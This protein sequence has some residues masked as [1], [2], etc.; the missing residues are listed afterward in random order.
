[1]PNL[2]NFVSL[3]IPVVSLAVVPS[4]PYPKVTPPEVGL[5][6][7][8]SGVEEAAKQSI[9]DEGGGFDTI[10]DDE[11]ITR[12]GTGVDE[13]ENSEG[14]IVE[15]PDEDEEI[16]KAWRNRHDTFFINQPN[17]V[18]PFVETAYVPPN[19]TRSVISGK[20]NTPRTLFKCGVVEEVEEKS[21]SI[22]GV[23]YIQPIIHHVQV[24][25]QIVDGGSGFWK[26]LQGDVN[27]TLV[28]FRYSI[29]PEI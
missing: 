24:Y 6:W 23:T 28:E 21:E 1:M 12:V 3:R 15:G 9:Q 20:R 11:F 27:V 22:G 18:S 2:S 14:N 7:G 13:A 19:P 8:R 25:F 17:I 29:T 5:R 4:S 26:A 16:I 10:D